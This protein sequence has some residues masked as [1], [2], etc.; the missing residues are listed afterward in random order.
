MIGHRNKTGRSSRTAHKITMIALVV[1]IIPLLAGCL[2]LSPQKDTP[3]GNGT[4]SPTTASTLAASTAV[5]RPISVVTSQTN[6]TTY[7]GGY[8][9]LTI[10]TS[11]YAVSTITISYGLKKASTA[12]GMTPHV[13]NTQGMVSWKWWVELDA[14]TGVWPLTIAAVLPNGSKTSTT[15]NVTVTFPPISIDSSQTQLSSHP[16]QGMQLTIVTAPE[17]SCTIQYQY[18]PTQPFRSY[19]QQA[20]WAGVVNWQWTVGKKVATG[21]YP[22]TVIVVLADGEQTSMQTTMTVL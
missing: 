13:A 11:P 5:V 16:N 17:A 4:A 15:V 6:L 7:A 1:G 18:G 20:S 21:T 2:S 22:L 3:L 19:T 10:T 14:H 9:N 12:S 8:M